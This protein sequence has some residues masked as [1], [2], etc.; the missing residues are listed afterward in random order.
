MNGP[1]QA[2]RRLAASAIRDGYKPEALHAYTDP[3]GNTLHWRIRLKHPDTKDKWIRPMRLN[4]VGFEL[5]EPEYPEGKPLYRLHELAA[6]LDEQVLVCEGEL[7]ADAL[8]KLGA[9]ATTSGAADSA[10]KADWRPLAG[11]DVTIWPDN[12]EVGQRYAAEAAESL[13]ALGCTVCVIDVEALGLPAKGDCA[14]WLKANP[15]ASSADIAALPS[16]G[17][18]RRAAPR[19]ACDGQAVYRRLFDIESKPIRWLWQGRIARGKV[20]MLAGHPG[21]GKS[22]AMI[23]MAAIVT[24]GGTWPVDRTPCAQGSVIVLSAEDDA[25]DTIRPRLEAAGADLKRVY[26]LDAIRETNQDGASTKRPFNLTEDIDRLRGLAR[27]LGDV[28]LIVI[29][30]VTAYLGRVD[31]HR[32]AEVRAVLAPLAETAAEVRAAIVCVSHLNKAGGAEALL[33]VMG[34]LGFVAAARGAYLIAKDPEDETRRLFL[35]MKNNLAEDRGGLAFRVKGRILESG[36]ER[37]AT[38]YV[39]WDAEPVTMTADQA[40]APV[41]DPEEQSELDG[42]VEWLRKLLKDGPV[43]SKQIRSDAKQAG[44]AWRTVERAKTRLGV[45]VSKAGYQGKWRWALPDHEGPDEDRQHPDEDCQHPNGGGLGGLW[46]SEAPEP[47]QDAG[48]IKDRQ[49]PENDPQNMDVGGLCSNLGGARVPGD[50]EAK[51]RQDRQGVGDSTPQVE[52]EL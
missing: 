29:D 4:G 49:L 44:I 24:T 40:M 13:L 34:S 36:T 25:E 11:R 39:E 16:V 3:D 6:R 38:S 27:E 10:A 26:I 18:R 41:G 52:V 31:S 17:A 46:E 7:C 43:D 32:N 1:Q 51:D 2:A 8:A 5:G 14:D 28:A 19:G 12:A 45:K 15:A 50:P 20:F 21:L 35:P 23:S 37:I 48:S 47:R 9:L 22:Q 42:A 30:P 33:R